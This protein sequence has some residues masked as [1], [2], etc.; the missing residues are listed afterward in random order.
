MW[1]FYTQKKGAKND[2]SDVDFNIHYLEV[3]ILLRYNITLL[4][5]ELG[6][7]GSYT[8]SADFDGED[9]SEFI[10]NGDYGLIFGAGITLG[11]IGIDARYS[12]GLANIS[13]F[14]FDNIKN[15]TI[16]LGVEFTF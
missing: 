6:G 1:L 5:I 15:S 10:K 11:N 12:L 9:I 2:N 3:P 8:L 4:F 7:Y 13:S 14:D 16:T